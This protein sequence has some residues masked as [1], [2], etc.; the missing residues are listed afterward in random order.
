[1]GKLIIM[2]G[3]PGSGKSTYAKKLVQNESKYVSVSRDKIRF[4]L[5]SPV[6]HYFSKENE[7][8]KTYYKTISSFLNMGY[9]VIADSSNLTWK[10]RKTLITE[11]SKRSTLDKVDVIYM[12]PPL[13]TC[14][15]RNDTREGRE[16]VPHGAITNMWNSQTDPANDPYHYNNI[17]YVG[18]ET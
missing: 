18:D 15:Q 2:S 16:N 17:I 4:S 12:R 7:V 8:L 9:N 11:V 10:A 6:N 1:M 5:L 13:E 14:F 3:A